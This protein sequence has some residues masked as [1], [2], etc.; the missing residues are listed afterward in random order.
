M[1]KRLICPICQTVN[2]VEDTAV[3]CYV[4]CHG[5]PHRFY[6]PVPPLGEALRD[7]LQPGPSVIPDFQAW[8]RR[9]DARQNGIDALSGAV[10]RLT[11]VLVGILILQVV[12]ALLVLWLLFAL[13]A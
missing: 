10:R 12:T 11:P 2:E 7:E 6:V 13:R 4:A 9:F 8:E 3:G 1:R 5:C